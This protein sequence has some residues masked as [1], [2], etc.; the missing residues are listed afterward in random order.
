M[1]EHLISEIIELIERCEDI[2]L[3]DLIVRLL[4]KHR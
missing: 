4:Q 3:L 2:T 1:K